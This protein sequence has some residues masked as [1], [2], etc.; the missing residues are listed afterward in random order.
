M[1]A[2]QPSTPANV[3]A[4]HPF[5]DPQTVVITRDD[6]RQDV[7]HLNWKV[8]AND[9]L[10]LLGIHLGVLPED[11]LMLDG[12]VAYDADDADAVSEATDDLEP[13]LL[14]H[15]QVQ[16]DG[17]TCTGKVGDVGDLVEEGADVAF[18]CAAPVDE[19]SVTVTTLT[20]LHEAYR[21]LATAPGGQRGVYEKSDDTQ[22]W[23]MGAFHSGS[24]DQPMSAGSSAALQIGGVLGVVVLLAVGWSLVARRR[25]RRS[26]PSP[27][28]P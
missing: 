18:T 27:L 14:E 11:R 7:V 3:V 13:Y 21:T 5:G 10:T 12:A 19:V 26:T 24:S 17:A 22:T 15:L 28:T 9:D 6:T 16:V 20:D 1:S 2:T 8:G 4:L 23:E 25:R